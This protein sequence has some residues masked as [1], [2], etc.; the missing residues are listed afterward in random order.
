MNCICCNAKLSWVGPKRLKPDG[1]EEDMC[2]VCYRIALLASQDQ[3]HL[4]FERDYHHSSITE[5]LHDNLPDQDY[6]GDIY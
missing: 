4:F 3:D 1:K 5:K 6:F 2:F